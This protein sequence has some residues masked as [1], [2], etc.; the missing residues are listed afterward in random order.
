M[1]DRVLRTIGVLFG[2]GGAV[3]GLLTLP[4]ILAQ[5]AVTPPAWTAAA[6]VT[7]L[8]LPIALGVVAP[9][10]PARTIRVLGG[11][12]A[13]THLLAIFTDMFVA[14]P[15]GTGSPWVLQLTAIGTTG[16]ALGLPTGLVVTDV[17]LTGVLVF[18]DRT[19]TTSAP[20]GLIPLQDAA[21]A[22]LFA[23]VFAALAVSALRAGRSVDR[24]ADGAMAATRAARDERVRSDERTRVNGLVHDHVLTTLLVAARGAAPTTTI[25]EDA[26]DALRRLHRLASPDDDH[27]P[28]R[29]GEVLDR[30]RAQLT[31][32][33]PDAGFVVEGHRSE[34]V[35]ARAAAA[36]VGAP[37][38]ALR[39]ARKHA[40]GS[41]VEVHVALD[42]ARVE[43]VIVDDGKGFVRR[44][45]PPNRL[46]IVTSIEGRM[47]QV[48]GAADVRSQ[49][50]RGTAVRLRWPAR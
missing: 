44:E 38:A 39:N 7:T 40:P 36:L 37:A 5:L 2:V 23:A 27:E 10:A 21:F 19:V 20:L 50:G 29:V 31:S 17:L 13:V 48:C 6:L 18:A 42:E 15:D 46:G 35:E 41:A 33:A 3:F 49:R 14:V 8:G 9:F 1:E 32:I 28:A 45:V 12:V 30:L 4:V 16:A 47:R 24:A 11:C 43:I 34:P 22:T 25:A 26:A